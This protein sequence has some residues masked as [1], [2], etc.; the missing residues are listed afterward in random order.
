[1]VILFTENA[2]YIVTKLDSEKQSKNSKTTGQRCNFIY[3]EV[4][5][6]DKGLGVL[7]FLVAKSD[8]AVPVIDAQH[9][10]RRSMVRTSTFVP[11]HM[12]SLRVLTT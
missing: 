2:F 7:V 8:T 3:S 4:I 9:S 11:P 5:T 6:E 1:M 12:G 10:S